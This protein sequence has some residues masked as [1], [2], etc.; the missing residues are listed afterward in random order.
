MLATT[1]LDDATLAGLI[2][3]LKS[4]EGQARGVQ[5]ML[6]DGRDCQEIMDQLAALR[7]ATHAV[8]MQALEA[9]IGCCFKESDE[10]SEKLITQFMGVVSKLAR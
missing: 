2:A 7:A 5:H 8:S 3:R 1:R 9:F 10:P 4:I 6:A